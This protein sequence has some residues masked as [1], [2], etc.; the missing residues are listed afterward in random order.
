M[1][2]ERGLRISQPMAVT[3][4]AVSPPAC[5]PAPSPTHGKS[6]RAFLTLVWIAAAV[7]L[8]TFAYATWL[9]I[10]VGGES[11]SLGWFETKRGNGWYVTRVTAGGG[12]AGRLEPGDRLGHLN[13]TPPINPSGIAFHRRSLRVGKT[14]AV[15][16]ERNGEL[17]EKQLVVVRGPD[18]LAN[19][20]TY[21]FV[22]LV[23]CVVGLFIGFARPEKPLARIGCAAAVA[24]GMVFLQVS[25]IRS[26]PIWQPL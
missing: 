10:A 25:V 14:Y 13:G 17:L 15:A 4:S 12:A 23:W 3:S 2:P 22:S 8:A 26:G 11:I 16:V 1:T 7:S 19:R 24:T 18:L 21:F 9:L 20:L 6:Q 5:P